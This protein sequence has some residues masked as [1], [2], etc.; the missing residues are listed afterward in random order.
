MRTIEELCQEIES[1]RFAVVLGVASDLR[2]FERGAQAEPEM[3]ELAGQMQS[4]EVRV[5]VCEHA[6]ALIIASPVT[7]EEP[8]EDTAIAVYLLLLALHDDGLAEQAALML[9]REQPWW[10]ARKIAERILSSAAPA[11]AGGGGLLP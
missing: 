3:A 8:L 11:T 7:Q 6:K 9:P 4:H 1:P 5:Q 10:W 2:T